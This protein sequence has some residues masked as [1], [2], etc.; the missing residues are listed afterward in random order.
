MHSPPPSCPSVCLLTAHAHVSC[1]SAPC[2]PLPPCPRQT[3]AQEQGKPLKK[4]GAYDTDAYYAEKD[5][6]FGDVGV[7]QVR[8]QG[9]GWGVEGGGRRS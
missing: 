5:Q 4:E 9:R 8:G 3:R 6:G 7:D 2:P 1:P